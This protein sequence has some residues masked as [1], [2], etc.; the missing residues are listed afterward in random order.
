M[1][2]A[3]YGDTNGDGKFNVDDVLELQGL[4]AGVAGT[5]AGLDLSACCEARQLVA[6]PDQTYDSGGTPTYQTEDS[7]YLDNAVGGYY[8]FLEPNVTISCVPGAQSQSAT[9]SV[10]VW[11]KDATDSTGQSVLSQPM[12]QG[13]SWQNSIVN[14][15]IDTDTTGEPEYSRGSNISWWDGRWYAQAAYDGDGTWSVSVHPRRG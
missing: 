9:N 7:Y 5:G 3:V 13:G 8:R 4:L 6:N 12:P 2:I 1:P 11:Q 15:E 10:R 14:I